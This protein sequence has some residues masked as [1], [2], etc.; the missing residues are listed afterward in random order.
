MINEQGNYLEQI[1]RQVGQ[2]MNWVRQFLPN[3]T[4]TWPEDLLVKQPAMEDVPGIPGIQLPGGGDL[5][6]LE[7]VAQN[8]DMLKGALEQQKS[9]TEMKLQAYIDEQQQAWQAE[10]Q[11]WDTLLS[12]CRNAKGQFNQALAQKKQEDEQEMQQA[13]DY[14]NK[15]RANHNPNGGCGNNVEDLANASFNAARVNYNQMAMA[16]AQQYA[17]MCAQ[18]NNHNNSSSDNETD[19]VKYVMS[20]CKRGKSGNY[21]NFVLQQLQRSIGSKNPQMYNNLKDAIKAKDSGKIDQQWSNTSVGYAV[22][23]YITALETLD[24][25]QT[26]CDAYKAAIKDS[27]DLEVCGGGKDGKSKKSTTKCSEEV[28]ALADKAVG[29]F[30]DVIKGIRNANVMSNSGMIGQ[31]NPYNTPCFGQNNFGRMGQGVL[32]QEAANIMGASLGAFQ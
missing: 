31:V 26:V 20:K 11:K 27:D 32:G 19:S 3:A 22:A 18:S 16:S 21:Q 29:N 5:S 10:Q 2:E 1:K 4:V 15:W 23:D 24:E 25:D 7:Q 12:D 6:H 28:E 9:D 13:R 14:C 17:A 30:G 8:I